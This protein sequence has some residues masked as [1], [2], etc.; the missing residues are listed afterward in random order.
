MLAKGFFILVNL[1]L[2]P[3]AETI[4]RAFEFTQLLF[5]QPLTCALTL[6]VH[7]IHPVQ[8]GKLQGSS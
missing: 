4:F 8:Y 3:I 1:L 6:C 5:F 7:I 2:S